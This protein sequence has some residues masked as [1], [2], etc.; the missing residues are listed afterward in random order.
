MLP[1]SLFGLAWR[2][3]RDQ[4]GWVEFWTA[5]YKARERGRLAVAVLILGR[6]MPV[7]LIGLALLAWNL[8]GP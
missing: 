6:L 4:A 5:Y 1:K 8:Y 2:P 7:V 3:K